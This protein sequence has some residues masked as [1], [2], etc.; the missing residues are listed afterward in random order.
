M[1]FVSQPFH[2]NTFHKYINIM[3][4]LINCNQTCH[5]FDKMFFSISVPYMTLIAFSYKIHFGQVGQS[6]DYYFVFH[7]KF[8]LTY[9]LLWLTF[10]SI[11]LIRSI[12]AF[13]N[14]DIPLRNDKFWRVP[15]GVVYWFYK[16]LI[17]FVN[18]FLDQ[19]F[20]D[21]CLLWWNNNYTIMT[22]LNVMF[23]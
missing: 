14:N 6:L 3:S 10:E 23:D 21:F 2:K 20:L 11:L 9:F 22:W 17:F 7:Q 19:C 1:S 8:N 4:F 15:V 5:Y 16:S 12:Y 13:T 18:S